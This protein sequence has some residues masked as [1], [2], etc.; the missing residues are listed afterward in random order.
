MKFIVEIPD[1]AISRAISE[2]VT[3]RRDTR[4]GSAIERALVESGTVELIDREVVNA[5]NEIVGDDTKAMIK[6]AVSQGVV[7]AIREKT[8]G[9]VRSLPRKE[10][11]LT[12]AKM[13]SGQEE[14]WRDQE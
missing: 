6:Q 14:I 11:G 2:A 9:L 1:E 8:K 3:G 12:I 10:L 13:L 5:V 7:D 4:Y